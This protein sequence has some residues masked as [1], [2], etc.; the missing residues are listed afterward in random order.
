MSS[1]LLGQIACF[2]FS[3]A[4]LG[5]AFFRQEVQTALKGLSVFCGMCLVVVGAVGP[6]NVANLTI[7]AG[8]NELSLSNRHEPTEAEKEEALELLA[9]ASDA[10][11]LEESALVKAAEERTPEERSGLDYLLLAKVQSLKNEP[12]KALE[13]AYTG[14]VIEGKDASVQAELSG[15]IGQSFKDFGE[16]KVGSRYLK[17]KRELT[18]DPK[19]L[20]RIRVSPLLSEQVVEPEG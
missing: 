14:R 11:E 8:E 4:L 20:E 15:V 5:L 6:E 1:P 7:R 9:E 16:A 19:L 18:L 2:V 10:D 17:E 3:F 12:A 13:Y